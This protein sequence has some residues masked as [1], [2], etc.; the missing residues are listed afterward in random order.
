MGIEI[1]RLIHK[2][3]ESKKINRSHFLVNWGRIEQPK[4][5]GG[6]G[7]RLAKF[8]MSIEAAIA[9]ARMVGDY[10]AWLC[11]CMDTACGTIDRLLF[12]SSTI[13]NGKKAKL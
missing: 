3:L 5:F 1:N 10:K 13:A 2:S 7:S 9:L 6:L 4:K 11:F 12:N 8:W